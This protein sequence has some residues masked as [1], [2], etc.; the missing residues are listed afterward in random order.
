[1]FLLAT[2]WSYDA[3]ACYRASQETHI[4][5][6]TQTICLFQQ[7]QLEEETRQ[8]LALSS[9]LRQLESEKEALQEQVEEEEEMK[10]NLE[11]QVVT[12]TQNLADAK[13]RIEEEAEQVNQLEE[14]KKKLSKVSLAIY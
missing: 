12:M 14:V 3:L 8:K 1:M 7:T 4:C 13:K 2:C 9:R 6:E 11:K 5:S 10:K